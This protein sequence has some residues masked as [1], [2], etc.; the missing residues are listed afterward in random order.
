MIE[1]TQLYFAP[2]VDSLPSK[3]DLSL[4]S[5]GASLSKQCS[6]CGIVKQLNEFYRQ[7]TKDGFQYQ[8]KKCHIQNVKEW[9]NKNPK[10]A[11]ENIKIWQQ[12][13]R[14]KLQETKK[15]WYHKNREKIRIKDRLRYKK[16]RFT[17]KE[18]LD[19]KI[20][21]RIRESLQ[22]NKGGR[23]WESL[24]GYTI[25]DLKQHIESLFT[26]GMTWELL[27]QGKIHIDHKIPISFFKYDKPEDQ[28][29]QYCWSLDNIQPLWAK[30]NLFKY[31]KIM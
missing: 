23:H 4:H 14:A 11:L 7:T 12:K 26:E 30:D 10:K 9:R 5:S 19:G 18:N 31:N 16:K 6:K 25:N 2:F 27:M 13:N 8:C 3:S 20:S 29:F 22:N 1:S 21:R 15:R 17:I 24:V 28:E